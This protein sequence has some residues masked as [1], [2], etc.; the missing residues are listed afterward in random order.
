MKRAKA[1]LL[2]EATRSLTELTTSAGPPSGLSIDR[3]IEKHGEVVALNFEVAQVVASS[4]GVGLG[5]YAVL[6][7]QEGLACLLVVPAGVLEATEGHKYDVHTRFIGTDG[8][9]WAGRTYYLDH[10][11]LR[12]V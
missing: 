11:K 12:L 5:R 2:E 1:K 4:F 6:D 10:S 9:R 3:R 7:A 8:V